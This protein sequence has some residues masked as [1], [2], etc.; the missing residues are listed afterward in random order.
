MR[1][2]WTLQFAILNLQFSI[3]NHPMPMPPILA[4]PMPVRLAVLFV[5]GAFLG[6]VVNWAIYGLAWNPRPISPWSRPDPAAPRRRWSDRLP[7]V[8]WLGLRREAPLHGPGFWIRPMLLELCTA[9]GLAA[10]YW[11]E[12]GYGGLLP[13]ILRCPPAPEWWPMLHLEFA[14][15][16]V[17]AALMLAASMIDVDEKIIPDEI[18]VTGTLVG[19]LAA[20]LWP[21]SL[22]PEIRLAPEPLFLHLASPNDWP[23]AL[24]GAPKIGSLLLGWGCWWAW[25]AAILPRRWR[26]RHGWRRAMQLCWARLA[27]TPGTYRILQMA[28]VGTLAIGLVWFRGGYHWCGLLSALVGMAAGGGIVWAVRIVGTAVLRRE[29]M[30][31]GDVT[32][33][34]M[35]GAF[36]GWQPCPVIFFLA[37]FAGIVVGVARV[38]LFRDKEIPFG[39]FLC[40]ATMF[41]IVCWYD[42]W[43]VPWCVGCEPLKEYFGVGWL[44]PA[45]MLGCPVLLGAMLGAWRLIVSLCRA[46]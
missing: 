18:T 5:L 32:L 15:H 4:I 13:A 41:V 11:W 33:M 27:R 20:A 43:E 16:T 36:V 23:D 45:V 25:C 6:G 34:A 28:A 37:P 42:I 40:L 30:G 44:V 22:L 35:I 21:V 8:G 3:Y 2:K 26:S 24:A 9:A 7:V 46:A 10:L 1:T 14:A 38:I 29:A 19:L 17:L 12:V 39:P 31:F